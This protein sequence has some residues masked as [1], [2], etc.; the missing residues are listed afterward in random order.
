MTWQRKVFRETELPNL[1][2]AMAHRL[3]SLSPGAGFARLALLASA[4]I[5]L[6]P[7]SLTAEADSDA[8]ADRGQLLARGYCSTCHLYPEPELLDKKTWDAGA[9]ALM[10]LRLGIAPLDFDRHPDGEILKGSGVIP[11]EGLISAPDWN[12][13]TNFY[14]S[15]APT[16]PLPQE[17]R[18][19]ITVGL[20]LFSMR[21]PTY[22]RP[23]PTSTLLQVS[24]S[25]DR[26]FLGDAQAKTLD[27]LNAAGDLVQSI[28]IGNIPVDVKEADDG[29]YLI[30]VG[31]FFPSDRREGAV[32][33]L[34]RGKDGVFSKPRNVLKELARPVQAVFS[35]LNGDGRDDILI[36]SFGNLLGHF[37]WF[38]NK[39]DGEYE[40]KILLARPGAIRA[41]VR[42]FDGDGSLD[43]AVLI[44]Q[45]LEAFF[46]YYN[47]G[48]GNFSAK[49][50]F[51][52]HP[53]FGH[54]YFETADFNG[55]GQLD[56]VVTNGDNGEYASPTKNYHGVRIYLNRGKDS[57][58]ESYF[59]PMNGAFKAM[60]RDFDEDGDLD[61]AA[62]SYFPD[63]VA[64]PRESFVYLRNDGHLKF[65]PSTFPQCIG[66][67]WLTMDVADLDKDGDLE[68][69]LGSV[70]KGPGAVPPFLSE[71][72]HKSGPSFVVLENTLHP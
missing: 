8:E 13:I 70:I 43:I 41:D 20:D 7:L 37:S 14:L 62:I 46:I 9:L 50:I 52:R 17:K 60:A 64:S 66:G 49:P 69:L 39:G 24:Q 53:I 26:I 57:F 22:R 38:E 40:E 32:F 18:P 48:K 31:H 29:I 42:D 6:S 27:I 11:A 45:D 47:D 71:M 61:I 72:W 55:D 54:T 67:R 65:S 3:P 12:A 19:E 4:V 1:R 44:A 15:R 25:G 59:F 51:Q 16:S 58:E 2:V 5:L 28:D 36:C 33:F 35:D 56:L 23:V 21:P 30:C 10:E 68:I 34:E 63:Y